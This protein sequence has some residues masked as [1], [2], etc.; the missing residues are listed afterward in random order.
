MDA[1]LRLPHGRKFERR[2]MLIGRLWNQIPF[3]SYDGTPLEAKQHIEKDYPNWK[4][5]QGYQALIWAARRSLRSPF[6][7]YVESSFKDGIWSGVVS[8][9]EHKSPNTL[10]DYDKIIQRIV[11]STYQRECK[12]AP[13]EEEIRTSLEN[14][15]REGSE[16][17]DR[18]FNELD[19]RMPRS[20]DTI[21]SSVF[22]K[23]HDFLIQRDEKIQKEQ[24]ALK[25]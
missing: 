2:I 19:S 18:V 13:S 15:K 24:D 8:R 3:Y 25:K 1:N 14:A 20:L 4:E 5:G 17:F 9:S 16:E 11:E 10:I 7:H 6:N 12:N 23:V 21:R 22:I